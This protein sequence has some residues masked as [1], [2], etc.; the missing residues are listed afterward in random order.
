LDYAAILDPSHVDTLVNRADLLIALGELDRAADDV[1]TGLAL[2]A[3][4]VR[5]LCAQGTLLAE[6]EQA[7]AAFASFTA[8]LEA[9]PEFAAAWANRAIIAYSAGRP[10]DAVDDLDHAVALADDPML[11]AN[12]ALA[13][14]ELGEHA[15]ALADLDIA[16]PA[17]A[18]E[19]PDLLYRRGTAR[20]ALGDAEG[21]RADFAAHLAAYAELGEASPFAADLRGLAESAA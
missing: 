21:A 5:L 4:N 12:R 3:K 7:E 1:R 13:L 14:Q 2:D 20:R 19:D 9:D 8:A 10:E 15:R 16:V 18:D 11:R 17:L 6:S